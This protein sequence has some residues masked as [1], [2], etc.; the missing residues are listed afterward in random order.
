MLLDRRNILRSPVK[1]W[2][3]FSFAVPDLCDLWENP[4]D[5]NKTNKC[6]CLFAD[7]LSKKNE[8]LQVLVLLIFTLFASSL[9][10]GIG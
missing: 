6:V 10:N 7:T 3:T 8:L 9:I 4:P 1:I 5:Q 2:T